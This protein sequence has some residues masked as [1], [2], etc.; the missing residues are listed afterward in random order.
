MLFV[1]IFV[2]LFVVYVKKITNSFVVNFYKLNSISINKNK[3]KG[4]VVLKVSNDKLPSFNIENVKLDLFL[5][6][7]YI[8]P[9]KSL[10]NLKNGFLLLSFSTSLDKILK[11]PELITLIKVRKLTLLG[12]LEV[13]KSILKKEININESFY[14]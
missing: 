5:N 14:L 1:L 12:S 10:K 4:E 9:V 6:D 7:I 11:A 2:A 8:T 3:L 13:H